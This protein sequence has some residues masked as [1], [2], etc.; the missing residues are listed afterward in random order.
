MLLEACGS[1]SAA[2]PQRKVAR[3]GVLARPDHA[4]Q[5]VFDARLRELGW[6]EGQNLIRSTA[7]V[8]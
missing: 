8:S 4:R 5:L 3:V 2:G 1:L 6:I 7:T